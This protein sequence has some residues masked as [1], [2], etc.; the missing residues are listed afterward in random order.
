MTVD[1]L[2]QVRDDYMRK[3][4]MA[5]RVMKKAKD[6]YQV[7]L[8]ED[9]IANFQDKIDELNAEIAEEKADVQ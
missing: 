9:D 2:K 8:V 3:V 7:K 4:K 1:T 6:A 5:Q